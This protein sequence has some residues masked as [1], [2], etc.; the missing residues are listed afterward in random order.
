MHENED[1]SSRNTILPLEFTSI[2][3]TLGA[4]FALLLFQHIVYSNFITVK[5]GSSCHKLRL[6]STGF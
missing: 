1:E 6:E 5:L 3:I 2:S 4:G